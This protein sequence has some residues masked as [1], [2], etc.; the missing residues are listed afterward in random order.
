MDL[1]CHAS[2]IFVTKVDLFVAPIMVHCCKDS[3]RLL[4]KT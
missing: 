1:I 4:A 2:D 3:D